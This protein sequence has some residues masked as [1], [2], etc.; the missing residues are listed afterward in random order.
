[1]RDEPLLMSGTRNARFLDSGVK[2]NHRAAGSGSEHL[3]SLD[4]FS[5]IYTRKIHS[6]FTKI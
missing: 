3:T 1:M 5:Y 6:V 2:D 4:S